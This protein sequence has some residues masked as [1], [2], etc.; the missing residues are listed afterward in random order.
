MKLLYC[1][2]CGDLFNLTNEEKT[3]KCGK[4]KGKYFGNL[5]AEVSGGIPIGIQNFSFFN[6]IKARPRTG[7]GK[8]FE[9]FVIPKIC[10]T[11]KSPAKRKERADGSKKQVVLPPD[12]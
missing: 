5:Y 6:A 12:N 10:E 8:R 11:I 2:H 7:L 3:C 9:A 1:E 4:A